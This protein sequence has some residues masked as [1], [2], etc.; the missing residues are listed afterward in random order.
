LTSTREQLESALAG[1]YGFERELG[2]GGMATVYLA[3]DLRHDRPVAL[4]VLYPELAASL[5]SERFLR[6]IR[7]AARLQH[8]H[9]LTP[10]RTNPRFRKLVEGTA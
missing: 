9:I 5:G 6:E 10:L 7:M 8:P 4:K 1:R 3:R 2:R